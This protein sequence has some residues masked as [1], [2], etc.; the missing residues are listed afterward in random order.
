MWRGRCGNDW[1]FQRII[2][3]NRCG[4]N[5][6]LCYLAYYHFSSGGCQKKILG[7]NYIIFIILGSWCCGCQKGL[8]NVYGFEEKCSISDWPC[9]RLYVQWKLEQNGNWMI[10]INIF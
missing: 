6:S 1:W 7:S 4:D 10:L 8:S 5:S 2:D 3:E 9:I